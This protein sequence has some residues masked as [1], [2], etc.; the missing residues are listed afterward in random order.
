MKLESTIYLL[1]ENM[2]HTIPLGLWLLLH[3][4]VTFRERSM[5]YFVIESFRH[6]IYWIVFCA[7]M[8]PAG[9]AVYA[10]YCD[11]GGTYI[12]FF[13]QAFL[14]IVYIVWSRCKRLGCRGCWDVRK[15]PVAF[16][17]ALK[18]VLGLVMVFAWMM[19]SDSH[20]FHGWQGYCNKPIK[21]YIFNNPNV[22]AKAPK[23]GCCFCC[24]YP[25][26]SKG[27]NDSNP[28]LWKDRYCGANE[29]CAC[30]VDLAPLD[31]PWGSKML[32]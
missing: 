2:G 1:D 13:P 7:L 12:L 25:L 18:L 28:E 4:L 22:T 29:P 6:R 10:A 30:A 16:F 15:E 24:Y 31:G 27:V 17:V 19:M 21:S 23:F 11:Q 8:A 20:I 26:P 32:L 14:I 5:P 3:L 9:G